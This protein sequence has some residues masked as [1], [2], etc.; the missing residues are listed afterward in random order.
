MRSLVRFLD[1]EIP[2]IDHPAWPRSRP[3]PAVDG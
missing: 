1:D 2:F 3:R